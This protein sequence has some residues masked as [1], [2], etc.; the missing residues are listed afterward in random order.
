MLNG[1]ITS[2]YTVGI[3]VHLVTFYP[4]LRG[5]HVYKDM[6]DPVIGKQLS[7]CKDHHNVHD[8]Y[9]VAVVEGDTVAMSHVLH[10]VYHL[11]ITRGGTIQCQRLDGLGKAESCLKYFSIHMAA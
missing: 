3:K 8:V 1:T 6:L 2:Q 7:C 9:A 5:Y 4:N 11:F 10:T